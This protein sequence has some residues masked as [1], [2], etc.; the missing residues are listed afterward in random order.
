[1]E[2]ELDS[3]TCVGIVPDGIAG[4][5][6]CTGEKEVFLI[7]QR[8]GIA[9]FALRTGHVIV[10]AY[11]ASI[12]FFWGR[13]FLNIPRRVNVTMLVGK[14]I[15]TTKKE[16]K[17]ITPEDVDRVHQQLLDAVQDMFDSHKAA[18]GWGHKIM[19]FE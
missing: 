9:K 10:P 5:F 2:K 3:G 19:S 11:S 12:F 8:K 16:E 15:Y 6:Q 1:M 17:D 18:L 13:F 14:P 4:I 7:K